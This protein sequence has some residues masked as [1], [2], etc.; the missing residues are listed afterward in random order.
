MLTLAP[1]KVI[2]IILLHPQASTPV[3]SWTFENKSV[4]RIGRATDNQVVLYSAVVSRHHAEVQQVN[5]KWQIVN[6]GANGTY[7][8]NQRIPEAAAIADGDIFRL[9]QSGPRLQIRFEAVPLQP[10]ES[11]SSHK[12]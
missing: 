6:L 2:K 1:V 12:Q 7:L 10:K 3:Q 11:M 5:G 8:D 4:I 9:A